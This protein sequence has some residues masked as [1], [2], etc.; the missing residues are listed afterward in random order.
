MKHTIQP[1]IL[2]G[3]AGSRLWPLSRAKYPKQFLPMLGDESLFVGTLKRVGVAF[4]FKPSM[5]VANEH[6]RFIVNE[7]A[8]RAQV[9][10]GAL[11]LEPV[12]RNTAPAFAVAALKAAETDPDSLLLFLPSDHVIQDTTN[13]HKA[14]ETAAEA[15]AAGKLCCFGMTPSRPETGYGYIAQ[16]T[17]IDGVLGAF[18][19]A[20]FREKP[21]A[22]TAQSYLDDGGYSWNS[23]MFLMKASTLLAEFESHQPAMLKACE[24][25]LETVE[26]DLNFLRMEMDAFAAI[27]ADSIDYA[28][29][30]KTSQAAVV[31]AEFGWSDVGSFSSLADVQTSDSDG[32]VTIGDVILEDSKNCFVSSEDKLV[33]LVGVEDMIVVSTD[34]AVLVAPKNKD[35]DIK[36]IVTRLKADSRI[37]A[38]FHKTVYRP[39]GNYCGVAEGSRYQV[40]E[41]EVYPGKRLSLQKHH[42]RAEH[43]VIVEGSAIVTRDDEEILLSE[44]ES[45]YLPLGAVHRLTNPGKINLKLIE[46]QSGSY[47][48]EDD[49]V[50]L[51]D[52]FNREKDK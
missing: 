35:Q 5:V 36:K 13:F 40:K 38:D 25:A 44:N 18:E 37:E 51:E 33:A 46:V 16:G 7:Q 41:I 4:G 47:L 39:W 27:P 12:G 50:R 45:V 28:I 29:M 11:I 2:S 20:G 8:A 17:G 34:D 1:V 31:P 52:D 43:W 22:E 30:E 26:S 48:G 6:H 24:A 9:D 10:L 23:G 15:A 49:I 32:N 19:I 42:H 3:G 14:V 21:D